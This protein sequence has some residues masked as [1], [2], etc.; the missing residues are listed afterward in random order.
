MAFRMAPDDLQSHS[1]ISV[2][3]SMPTSEWRLV[4]NGETR[5]VKLQPRMFTNGNESAIAAASNGFGLT[6]VLSYQ[7]AEQ[8]AGWT[9]Q[10]RAE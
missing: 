9:T 4:E 5:V 1:I 7:V 8:L 10:D 2:N 3:P 6:R